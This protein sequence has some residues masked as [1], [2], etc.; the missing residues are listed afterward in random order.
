MDQ[1]LRI[2]VPNETYVYIR[3]ENSNPHC[4]RN[5]KQKVVQIKTWKS[6]ISLKCKKN[7]RLADI[8]KK[9]K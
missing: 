8:E 1:R 2:S 3:H 6:V 7:P 5:K 9:V 4:D